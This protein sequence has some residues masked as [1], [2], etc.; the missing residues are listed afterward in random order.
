MPFDRRVLLFVSQWDYGDPSRG[1]SSDQHF[2]L[3]AVR[4]LARETDVLWSDGAWLRGGSLDGALLERVAR[5]RPDLVLFFPGAD[6]VAPATLRRLQE[7]TT[8]LAFF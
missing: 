1:P 5:T 3:P 7:L 6:E 4:A 8:T 2:W